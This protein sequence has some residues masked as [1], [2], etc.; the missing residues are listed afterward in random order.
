MR[1]MWR[2]V[3]RLARQSALVGVV[4]LGMA[5]SRAC[6]ALTTLSQNEMSRLTAGETLSNYRCALSVDAAT[7]DINC[8]RIQYTGSGEGI[9]PGWYYAECLNPAWSKGCTSQS[10]YSCKRCT[11]FCSAGLRLYGTLGDCAASIKGTQ[12]GDTYQ[13]ACT[14]AN[15]CQSY[16]DPSCSC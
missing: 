10:G 5:V 12:I 6:A 7:C 14:G 2:G 11:M 16:Y 4:C 1:I 13:M 15:L 3:R 9:E 8:K